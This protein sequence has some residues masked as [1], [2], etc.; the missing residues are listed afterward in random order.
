MPPRFRLCWTNSRS[1]A[2]PTFSSPAPEFFLKVEEIPLLGT[3]KVDLE[4]AKRTAAQHLK[5]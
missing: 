2:S 3:G 5:G 4:S 1:S